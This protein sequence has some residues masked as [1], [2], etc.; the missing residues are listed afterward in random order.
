VHGLQPQVGNSRERRRLRIARTVGF[1]QAP[2][3]DGNIISGPWIN[4]FHLIIARASVGGLNVIDRLREPVRLGAGLRPDG[5]LSDEVQKRALSCLWRFGQRLR[6]LPPQTV[7]VVGTN[8]L[9]AAR[10]A[11]VFLRAA[12]EALGHRI[13]VIAGVEEA[14]LIYLGVAHSLAPTGERRLVVDIGGGS[15]E[16]IIGEGFQPL[17]VDS[18]QMGCVSFT[19]RFFPYGKLTEKKWNAAETAAR[20]E[21]ELVASVYTACA[22]K[23]WWTI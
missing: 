9:G 19:N 6:E 17:H 15:T 2:T 12:E 21:L 1:R 8:T 16:L 22:G 13:E 10:N 5:T 3:G 20:I 23:W 7:R 11:D 14:R 4:S 18:L